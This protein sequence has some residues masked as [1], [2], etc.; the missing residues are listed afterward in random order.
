MLE[1]GFLKP[2]ENPENV[3]EVKKSRMF[4]IVGIVVAVAALF[5]MMSL[6]QP[7]DS[8]TNQLSSVRMAGMVI[9]AGI[10][11]VFIGLWMN[12]FTQ[13]KKRRKF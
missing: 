8:L 7:D 10:A 2:K 3:R 9:I 4:I 5:F 1:K 11:L 13:N 12:F 6:L